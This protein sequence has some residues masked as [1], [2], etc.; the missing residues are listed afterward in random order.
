M[1]T[2][3]HYL[4]ESKI[5]KSIDNGDFKDLP[6]FGKPLSLELMNQPAHIRIASTIMKNANV[7][8][9]ELQIRKDV[10]NLRQ[11]LQK[12]KGES[13]RKAL[14]KQIM[15]KSTRYNMMMERKGIAG[16]L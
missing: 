1:L 13:E 5:Q 14:M 6:G 3:L 16:S 15:D 8:P 11:K 12:T 4:I 10:Y 2:G 9:E 7:L